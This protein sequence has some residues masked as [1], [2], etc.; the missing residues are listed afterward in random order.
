MKK[1]IIGIIVAAIIIGAVV[2]VSHKKSLGDATVSNYPTWYYNGIVIGPNNKL[3]SQEQFGTC[4]LTGAASTLANATAVLTCAVTGV[5]V[6]DVVNVQQDVPTV[7]FPVV[8]ARVA[9]AGVLSVTMANLTGGT[10]TPAGA[11]LA[12]HY[13]LYR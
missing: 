7:A 1:A 2:G 11:S 13:N 12:V 9:T 10:T 6:G 3:I 5:K 8:G 4:T